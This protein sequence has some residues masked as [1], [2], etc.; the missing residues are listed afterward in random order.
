MF[1]IARM[2]KK[3]C[4]TLHWSEL[5]P[6]CHTIGD[7]NSLMG[8]QCIMMDLNDK[9]LTQPAICHSLRN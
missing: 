7:N 5:L 1:S 6:Q 9:L 4:T 8:Q 3:C 2:C